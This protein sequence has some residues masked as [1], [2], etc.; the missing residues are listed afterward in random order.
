MPEVSLV[1]RA[2]GRVML[3]FGGDAMMGRRFSDPYPGDPVLIRPDHR[4]EDTR[5]LLRHMK[6]YLEL[7]DFSSV[8]LE[9]QVMAEQPE[10]KHQ[11]NS[12]P[13]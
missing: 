4:A 12:E 13:A 1:A 8:N 7:A 5:A 3:A 9:T 6:P 2:P 11:A 10:Q